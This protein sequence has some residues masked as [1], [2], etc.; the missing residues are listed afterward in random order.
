MRRK[1]YLIW[2]ISH[3]DQDGVTQESAFLYMSK[4]MTSIPKEAKMELWQEQLQHDPSSTCKE[5]RPS[6][7]LPPGA[8]APWVNWKTLNRFCSGVGRTNAALVK[9]GHRTGSNACICGTDPQRVDHLHKCPQLTNKC[10][11]YDLSKYNATAEKCVKLW[12]SHDN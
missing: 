2:K 6:E 1:I 5:M 7:S 12:T 8:N 3:S 4:P 9:R 10:T 11:M